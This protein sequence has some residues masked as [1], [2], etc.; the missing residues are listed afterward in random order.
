MFLFNSN[1]FNQPRALPFG[2]DPQFYTFSY[3]LNFELFER[4]TYFFL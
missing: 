3:L 1:L 4:I 2:W